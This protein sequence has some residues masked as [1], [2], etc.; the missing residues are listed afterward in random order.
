MSQIEGWVSS[1]S[2]TRFSMSLKPLS[3]TKRQLANPQAHLR[4]NCRSPEAADKP[5]ANA[6]LPKR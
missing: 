2:T 1:R 5:V 6:V 4:A 3:Q